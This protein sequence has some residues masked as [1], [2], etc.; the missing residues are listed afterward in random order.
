MTLLKVKLETLCRR[1]SGLPGPGLY[2]HRCWRPIGRCVTVTSSLESVSAQ[3]NRRASP[4]VWTCSLFCTE[5]SS[6]Q[7]LRTKLQHTRASSSTTLQLLEKLHVQG[8]HRNQW[9]QGQ[10]GLTTEQQQHSSPPKSYVANRATVPPAASDKD[11]YP[12]EE[13]G[14][15]LGRREGKVTRC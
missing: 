1:Y 8:A 13:G 3:Q 4:N 12:A 10:K 2:L 9:T 11:L 6:D 14:L 15:G 5:P 7:Y